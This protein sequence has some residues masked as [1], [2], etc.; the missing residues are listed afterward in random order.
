MANKMI[1]KKHWLHGDIKFNVDVKEEDNCGQCIHWK[2]CKQDKEHFCLNYSFGT[3]ED[4]SCDGCIHR[5]TR[6]IW[7]EKDGFPCFKCKFY[8]EKK[9]NPSKR[10]DK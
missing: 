9:L 7:Y 3:S 2:V 1:I 8:E 6:K 4:T 10:K 5:Y